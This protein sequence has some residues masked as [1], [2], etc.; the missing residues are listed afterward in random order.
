[1]ECVEKGVK[2]V[3]GTLIVQFD[4]FGKAPLVERPTLEEMKEYYRKN[5]K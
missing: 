5:E 1:M 3:V 4:A 2:E